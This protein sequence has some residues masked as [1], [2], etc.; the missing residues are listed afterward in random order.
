MLA[1]N[2]H[3]YICIILVLHYVF[4]YGKVPDKFIVDDLQCT[5]NEALL[6]DCKNS[7]KHNCNGHEGAGVVCEGNTNV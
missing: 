7:T 6:S 3:M 1:P 2:V 5:G 4:R